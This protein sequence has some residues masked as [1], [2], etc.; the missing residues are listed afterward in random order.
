MRIE[1]KKTDLAYV[2][3]FVDG[4]GCICIPARH[5]KTKSSPGYLRLL[6]V[7]TDRRPL[8][9]IRK[10][11]GGNIYSGGK[12]RPRR[13]PC[14]RWQVDRVKAIEALQLLLPYFHAKKERA[15]LAMRFQKLQL[16]KGRKRW[17]R[18]PHSLVCKLEVLRDRIKL[19]NKKGPA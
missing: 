15:V 2:A 3:G 10:V 8:V 6:V 7:N 17:A 16:S 18:T 9:F 19:L 12:A 4:E 13:K 5:W 11:M 1:P 14:F